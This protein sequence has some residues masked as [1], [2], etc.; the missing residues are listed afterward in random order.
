MRALVPCVL[1]LCGCHRAAE[2]AAAPAE[3]GGLV[4]PLQEGGGG[5]L[6]VTGRLGAQPVPVALD[7]TRALSLVAR[8]CFPKGAP[9]EVRGRVRTPEASGAEVEWRTVRVE[10]L[11]LGAV[12]L[13]R[14]GMGLSGG[15]A[16]EVVLGL[17]VLRPWA[18][19]VDPVRH[20]VALRPSQ[21]RERYE[22]QGGVVLELAAEPR[23]EWGVVAARVEGPDGAL[24][25][26]F[27]LGTREPASRLAG[28]ARTGR[29]ELAPGLAACDVALPAGAEWTS[30]TTLG[31]LGPDVWGRFH[32]VIDVQGR[33]L[34]L[35]RVEV[36]DGG[37][38]TDC[39]V[40]TNPPPDA[41]REVEPPDPE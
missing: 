37:A 3:L 9:P 23:G 32:A 25:G 4:L 36:M 41:V 5:A 35:R 15:K 6:V 8:A 27:V 10:G 20:E 7:V 26:P 30:A 29:V 28:R 12:P 31:R 33:A 1:M 14:Q 22:A 38:T 16:C 39:A 11:Q 40:P 24:T 2:P 21:P 17:D 13:P 18:L 19:Q 34:L